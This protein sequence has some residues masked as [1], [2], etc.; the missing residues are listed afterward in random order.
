MGDSSRSDID[1]HDISVVP[2]NSEWIS[3]FADLMVKIYPDSH[4]MITPEVSVKKQLKIIEECTIKDTGNLHSVL[5][6]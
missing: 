1:I 5:G 4:G 3:E 2:K 6:R